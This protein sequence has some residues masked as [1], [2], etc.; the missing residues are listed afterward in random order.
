MFMKKRL[1]FG[2]HSSKLKIQLEPKPEQSKAIRPGQMFLFNCPDTRV[3]RGMARK[4]FRTQLTSCPGLIAFATRTECSLIPCV[5]QIPT[6]SGQG[7]YSEHLYLRYLSV[8][9]LVFFTSFII[10]KCF[11]SL[12]RI[13]HCK[14]AECDISPRLLCYNQI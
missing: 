3:G 10:L 1:V 13:I 5:R 7:S 12:N 14:Y 2:F 6:L 8:T 11:L 9:K 4:P